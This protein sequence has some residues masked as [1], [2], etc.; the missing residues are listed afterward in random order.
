MVYFQLQNLKKINQ[1]S[2][3]SHLGLKTLEK[4][5]EVQQNIDPSID[6]T[7]LETLKH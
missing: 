4:R 3:I 2:K 6:N 7:F 5:V 1:L